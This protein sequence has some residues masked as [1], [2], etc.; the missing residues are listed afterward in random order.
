MAIIK[1]WQMQR[2][3]PPHFIH[4]I[5]TKGNGII[6]VNIFL[7]M[8]IRMHKKGWWYAIAFCLYKTNWEMIFICF[9]LFMCFSVSLCSILSGSYDGNVHVWDFTGEFTLIF[10][11]NIW[12]FSYM[13][14]FECTSSRYSKKKIKLKAWHFVWMILITGCL[15]ML[16]HSINGPSLKY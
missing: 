5:K 7:C 13:Y 12:L 4:E 1:R 15:Q 2:G 6:G 11:A 3:F 16:F 8:S 10:K 14:I 9:F